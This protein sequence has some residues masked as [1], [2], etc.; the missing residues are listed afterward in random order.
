[1]NTL[2]TDS[3]ISTP[4]SPVL[5]PSARRRSLRFLGVLIFIFGFSTGILFAQFQRVDGTLSIQAGIDALSGKAGDIGIDTKTIPTVW[6]HIHDSFVNQ[7]VDDKALI[8][9]AIAGMVAGLG[10][11]YSAYFT[12]EEASSFL[13]EIHG[14]FSGIGAEIASKKDRITVVSPLPDS[15]AEKAGVRAGDHVL[16]VDGVDVTAMSVS[17]VVSRIRGEK[18]TTVTLVMQ[19]DGVNEPLEFAIVRDTIQI[20]SVKWSWMSDARIAHIEVSSFSDDTIPAF[21]EAMDTIVAEQAE[22][23]VLDLRNNPGGYLNGAVDL[24]AQFVEKGS[25]VL[26][27]RRADG[28][29]KSYTTD[30]QPASTAIPLVVLIN[31]G[32][33]SAAE[34]VT[35]ALKDLGRAQVIGE[36]SFGKG[37][38]Q[39]VK[40]FQDGSL[41]KLTIAHWLT[42]NKTVIQDTGVVPTYTIEMT[43]EDFS[44]DRDPQLDA[45]RLF[46]RDNAA[47]DAQFTSKE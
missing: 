4:T 40:T 5:V 33:A 44:Q 28:S 42:P 35:G 11:P 16:L 22:G 30:M 9:N 21:Q 32:S 26:Y 29:E 17:E 31:E 8:Y 24:T 19:R 46:F 45:A 15:P 38:V 25:V 36:T 47:F 18:G 37:S 14:E 13:S 10:D 23:I 39:D 12:P 34:I 3:E 20:Q 2:N 6:D 27:E 41:L 1:M 43:A 7:P